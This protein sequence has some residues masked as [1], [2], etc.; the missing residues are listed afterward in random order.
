[1]FQKWQKLYQDVSS[2]MNSTKD[3]IGAY[4][5]LLENIHKKKE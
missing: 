2:T 4:I 5:E 1:M 3:H